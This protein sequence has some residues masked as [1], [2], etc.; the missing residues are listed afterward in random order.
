MGGGR[1][2][3]PDQLLEKLQG[4]VFPT[5]TKLLANRPR[6]ITKTNLTIFSSHRYAQ[7]SKKELKSGTRGQGFPGIGAGLSSRQRAP[8]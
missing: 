2:G 6:T 1:E 3:P 4:P 8:P 7:I 5:T